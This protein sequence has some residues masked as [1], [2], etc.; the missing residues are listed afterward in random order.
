MVYE[1]RNYLIYPVVNAQ[2]IVVQNFPSLAEENTDKMQEIYG[3][4][5]CKNCDGCSAV[6]CSNLQKI[7]SWSLN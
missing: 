2:N 6:D 3:T 1:T 4:E 5:C 7:I